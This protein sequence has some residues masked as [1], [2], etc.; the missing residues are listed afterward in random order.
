MS[1]EIKIEIIHGAVRVAG[2]I[3]IAYVLKVFYDYNSNNK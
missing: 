2:F 3:A 1:D